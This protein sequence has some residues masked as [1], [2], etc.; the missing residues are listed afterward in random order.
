MTITPNL[1]IQSLMNSLHGPDDAHKQGQPYSEGIRQLDL[2]T[3]DQSPN[4]RP[5]QKYRLEMMDI[6]HLRDYILETEY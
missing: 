3:R 4:S 6:S 5:S 2:K 1:P